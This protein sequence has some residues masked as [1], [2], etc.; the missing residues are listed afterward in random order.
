MLGTQQKS[1][2]IDYKNTDQT[3][4]IKEQLK[5]ILIDRLILKRV[6]AGILHDVPFRYINLS[7]VDAEREHKL[8]IIEMK[9]LADQLTDEDFFSV[10][11]A[12]QKVS[13][14]MV[15]VSC[16]GFGSGISSE[17]KSQLKKFKY[18]PNNLE[19]MIKKGKEL[20]AQDSLYDSFWKHNLTPHEL[21]IL[22]ICL[23]KGLLTVKPTTKTDGK[24][25]YDTAIGWIAAQ[26]MK[27]KLYQL[28]IALCE[29]DEQRQECPDSKSS[30]SPASANSTTVCN[31]EKVTTVLLSTSIHA[32]FAPAKLSTSSDAKK[33]PPQSKTA[34]NNSCSVM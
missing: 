33:Q 5:G 10:H 11:K 2:P 1:H 30:L 20:L 4:Q 24:L 31:N 21:N 29:Q 16:T 26:Q 22:L 25:D 8:L 34:A 15:G 13:A 19:E 17:Q 18:T 28:E 9:K 32:K 23:A 12:A 6:I 7:K 27:I 3:N 14:L